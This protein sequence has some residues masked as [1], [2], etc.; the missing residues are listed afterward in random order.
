LANYDKQIQK[1]VETEE[2]IEQFL[3]IPD[4]LLALLYLDFSLLEICVLA[5]IQSLCQHSRGCIA[6]NDYFTWYFDINV[7]TFQ[8]ILNKLK[9]HKLITIK[10]GR[11]EAHGTVRHIYIELKVLKSLKKE[12][13][14]TW[15]KY[16]PSNINKVNIT[17][18]MSPHNNSKRDSNHYP[19]ESPNTTDI[20]TQMSTRDTEISLPNSVPITTQMSSDH[21]PAV[22]ASI[23]RD[24]NILV[25]Y[26][27]ETSSFESSPDGCGIN[28]IN[29]KNNEIVEQ[30]NIQE[31]DD[32]ARKTGE[33]KLQMIAYWESINPVAKYRYLTHN[34][35][36]GCM[37]FAWKDYGKPENEPN[38]YSL[39]YMSIFF[40]NEMDWL[41]E[42]CYDTYLEIQ[43]F[44]DAKEF[45][46]E[47]GA[48]MLW[49]TDYD[50][51]QAELKKST[52]NNEEQK[53]EE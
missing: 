53:N 3:K 14:K 11:R 32:M 10:Y 29:S 25:N 35:P 43:R 12:A 13:K 6:Q 5:K 39:E 51:K 15:E 18:Q 24:D 44:K 20:T 8:R 1:E 38:F 37:A 28:N 23:V 27:K 49:I 36:Q 34:D 19:V 33:V 45:G 50:R 52:T 17:T 21:Y 9:S 48:E 47:F 22:G 7:K 4:N 42:H 26:N 41:K 46:E 2:E 40:M 16:H 31:D 30:K